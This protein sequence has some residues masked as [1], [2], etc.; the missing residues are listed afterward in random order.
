M[1]LSKYSYKYLYWV[2]INDRYSYCIYNL[3][4][5]LRPHEPLTIDVSRRFP[6]AS[7]GLGFRASV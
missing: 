1:G 7:F 5:E 4:T 2:L 6:K 3:V